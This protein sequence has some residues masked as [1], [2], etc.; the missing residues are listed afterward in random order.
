MFGDFIFGGGLPI[1]LRSLRSVR[2]L[3]RA[4]LPVVTR[5]P[6]AW[7]YPVGARQ[8]E[9][10]PRH[11]RFYRWADVIAGDFHFIR[12]SMPPDLAG[13]VVLTQTVTPQDV[14][15]LRLR[16]VQLLVADF[17]PLAGRSIATNVMQAAVVALLERRPE[18][19]RPDEYLETL[20]RAGV[21]PRI[22]WL[23][24]AP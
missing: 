23:G 24:S 10:R 19:I 16:G 5:L 13:K 21:M 1:G 6:F 3:A 17:S 9:I 18:E 7:L 15:E 22:E 8:T 2:L 14:E 11:Q 20:L 12:R 4:L